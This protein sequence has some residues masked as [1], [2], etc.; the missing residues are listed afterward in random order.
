M[1]TTTDSTPATEARYVPRSGETWRNPYPMYAALRDHD[2][3]HHVE[4]GDYWVLSRFEDVWAAARDTTTFSSAQGL[5][6][7]YGE[8][9][10]IGLAEASPIVMMDP[11]DHTAFRRLVAAGFTPRQVNEIEPAVRAFV[12]DRLE[13]LR[14]AGEVDIVAALFKPLPSFVVAHYLGV[15]AGDRDQFDSWTEAIV[16][17]N[18]EGNATNAAEK[19]GELLVYFSSLIDLRRAEP[20]DDLISQL[21]HATMRGHDGEPDHDVPVLQILGFAFTMV[22]GGN[23]TVTGL[24]G[25]AAELLTSQPSQRAAL[26]DDPGAI[27]GAVEEFLRLTSPVQGLARTTTRDVEIHGRTIPEGRKVLLSYS[28]ANRDPREF[29]ATAEDCDIARLVRHIMTFSYGAH[30]CL[31][32]AVARLQGRVVLEE[33]LSRFPGFTVDADAGRFASGNSVRR[34]KSLPFRAVGAG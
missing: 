29:G 23:D 25:G 2:P 5:T 22:A 14:G 3:V 1:T 15:P 16:E 33:L 28:S 9:E 20:S 27:P 12:I 19:L 30:H 32:A 8:R 26:I 31:G 7:T 10:K 21:V 24:L 4:S 17:A 34:Y 11:P 6:T 18:A 13:Q